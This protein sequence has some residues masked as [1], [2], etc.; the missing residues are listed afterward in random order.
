LYF[1]ALFRQAS[2]VAKRKTVSKMGSASVVTKDSVQEDEDVDMDA[3][4][5]QVEVKELSEQ[6]AAVARTKELK[7]MY[8]EQLKQLLLSNGLET[9]S[10]EVM[11]KNLLKHEAKARVAAKA[12]KNKIR[13]V[14]V[15]KKQDLEA[16]STS[17]LGKLC[18][19]SGMKGFK[20]KEER[21]QRLLVQWQE[22]DG[23][24]KALAQIAE[25]ERKQ[26]LDSLDTVKLQKLCAKMGVDPFVKEIMVERISKKENETGCYA[27]PA[28][29]Q[30]SEAPK[31]E[32]PVDMV[33]ALLANESQRKKDKE[34]RD[35]KEEASNQ[36]RKEIKALSVDDLKKR[37]GKK[38]L[39]ASGKK[40]DMVEA[41]FLLAMQ[42]DKANARA[43]ELKSKSLPELKEFVAK[44]GLDAGTKEQMVKTLLA[45]EA[46]CLEEFKAFEVKVGEVATLKK[47]E[48]A[49]KANAALKELC[50]AKG[51]PV[52]GGKE[53]KVERIV[54]EIVKGGE[55]DKVVS[56]NIRNKRK[57]E[58][59][60]MDKPSV[61]KL[62]EQAGVDPVVKDIIVERIMSHESE[63][64]AAIIM[65]DAEP[66]AKKARVTKK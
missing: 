44:K 43:A 16:L 24:D 53:E 13:A 1:L 59:M 32:K 45:H 54:E 63:G 40:D 42:E 22:N 20:S 49:G 38:G 64:G 57:D 17:E 25:E 14:V 55:L 29:T 62:C 10:K 2:M 47:E 56:I 58:L 28:L 11:I 5:V 37:I 35:Q 26:E 19:S 4:L 27:R 65:A 39:E 36:K 66:P 51:L 30:E 31:A 61:V 9:G 3:Q 48:L 34:Q 8:A 41:L 21:V 52:G 7:S 12:Q 18:E 6:D 50:V 46:K 23:V 33:D 60:S 15:K